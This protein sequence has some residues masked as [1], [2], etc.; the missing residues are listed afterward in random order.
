MRLESE[1]NF[2]PDV[3]FNGGV[4]E[5][6]PSQAIP[7]KEILKRASQGLPVPLSRPAYDKPLQILGDQDDPFNRIGFN[8]I[9]VAEMAFDAS[10]VSD[11]EILKK[12]MDEFKKQQA[13]PT[14]PS[15]PED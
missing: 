11:A 2:T 13:A 12:Q 8:P 14:A 6:T 10:A 9:D 4:S 3:E 1:Q 7:I 5:T 15:A